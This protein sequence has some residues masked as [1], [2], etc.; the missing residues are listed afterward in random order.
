MLVFL[1]TTLQ[2]DMTKLRGYRVARFEILVHIRQS[3]AVEL[4]QSPQA[5]I[6]YGLDFVGLH[7]Y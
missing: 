7:N 4:H 5:S 1:Q 2:F 6:K 3:L